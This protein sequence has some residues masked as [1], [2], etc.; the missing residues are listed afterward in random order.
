[1][2]VKN[3]GLLH[4]IR[5]GRGTTVNGDAFARPADVQVMPDGSLLVSE[6]QG[7]RVFRISYGK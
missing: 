3:D 5:N 1:M 7:G 2:V 4:G 6:D